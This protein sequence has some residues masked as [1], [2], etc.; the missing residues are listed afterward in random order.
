MNTDTITS[1]Q[2][3][4]GQNIKRLREI[5]GIKQETIAQGLNITQQ[6]MSKLEQKAEIE[7]EVLQKVAN[8]LHI[9]VEAIKNFNEKSAINIIANTFN[10]TFHEN[11]AFIGY[12][13]V[14]NPI[15]KIVELYERMLQIEREKNSLLER[16]I[17][18][19]E[20]IS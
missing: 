9:P 12:K 11:S 14:F 19:K 13:P 4:F 16:M 17:Q 15:E 18:E 10:D 6:A 2:I 5:L 3:H 8:F 7:D 20:S 1:E